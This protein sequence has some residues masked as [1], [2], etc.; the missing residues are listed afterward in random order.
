MLD[1]DNT[2]GTGVS[3]A[4]AKIPA[5]KKMIANAP[6]CFPQL[7]LTKSTPTCIVANG[8]NSCLPTRIHPL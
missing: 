8:R 4:V 1:N 3:E 2:T 7:Q 6:L 5:A